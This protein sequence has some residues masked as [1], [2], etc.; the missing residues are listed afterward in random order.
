MDYTLSIPAARGK[1]G[2]REFYTAVV[3]LGAVTK[4]FTFDPEKMAGLSPEERTQRA[5]AHKRIP[6]IANYVL[7]HEDYVFSSL[8]VSVEDAD[9][10]V[11]DP[12]TP[13]SD[14][15]TLTLPLDLEFLV[16]DGQHR[17]AGIAEAL[18]QDKHLEHDCISV[19]FLPG[20]SRAEAQQVF[21]DLNRTVQKTSRSLD[22]LFDHRSTINRVSVALA[23][24]VPL[25]KGRV[26]KERP[27][28]A[29]RS[30]D[31]TTLATLQSA[32]AQLL[33]DQEAVTEKEYR[34]LLAQAKAFW[35][36]LTEIIPPWADIAKGADLSGVLPHDARREYVSVYSLVLWALAS[37]GASAIRAVGEGGDWKKAL[38]PL[39]GI[40]WTKENPEW[41][42]VC[43]IG[44][45]VV[46]RGPARKATADL[47]RWKLGIGTKP[48]P[49]L[50]TTKP[51]AKPT[52]APAK[53]RRAVRAG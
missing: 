16:N 1:M 17:V 29:G 30:K 12:V 14:L 45:D 39:K 11:F 52:K 47:L 6:E 46:T 19:V 49:V 43:M 48:R 28:L 8:T 53:R 15:G 36:H 18:A 31:F 2:R 41:Q 32:T 23:D 5:I 26:D 7:E 3:P 51:A 22:I 20:L 44:P 33:G 38:D 4:L 42:G 40:D 35:T 25:F 9:R 21:S 34:Q 13:G 50:T 37:A 24:T 27:A 10:V